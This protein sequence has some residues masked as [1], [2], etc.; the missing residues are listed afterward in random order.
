MVNNN[1]IDNEPKGE[2]K[3]LIKDNGK[4]ISIMISKLA[5]NIVKDKKLYLGSE[6]LI[7]LQKL[8]NE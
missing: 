8:K 1:F 7:A 2:I 6:L 4:E 3:I 5:L